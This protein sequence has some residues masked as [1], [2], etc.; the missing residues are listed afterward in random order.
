MTHQYEPAETDEIAADS[1]Q[2]SDDFEPIEVV[3]FSKTGQ[4]VA[5][6]ITR[7]RSPVT[8]TAREPIGRVSV[9]SVLAVLNNPVKSSSEHRHCGYAV[10]FCETRNHGTVSLL[11]DRNRLILSFDDREV[12]STMEQAEQAARTFVELLRRK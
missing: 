3:A 7:V 10:V 12:E 9:D 11:R 5:G 6:R 2:L 8:D 4:S 1:F